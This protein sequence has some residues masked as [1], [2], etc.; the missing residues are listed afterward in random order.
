MRVLRAAGAELEQN[1][2]FGVAGQL[3]RALLSDLPPAGRRAFLAEAP[4]RVRSLAG[5]REALFEPGD[6]GDLTMSHGLFTAMAGAAETRP[7]LLAIDDLHWC[8]VALLEF[9]LYVLHRLDELP[10]ALVMTRGARRARRRRGRARPCGRR[11]PPRPGRRG[12]VGPA[13]ARGAGAPARSRARCAGTARRG[14]RRVRRRAAGASPGARGRRRARASRPARGELHL[15]RVARPRPPAARAR[16]LRSGGGER[17]QGPPH[18]G[19]ATAA[20]PRRPAR[21][22]H[23]RVGAQRDRADRTGV[24]RRANARGSQSAVDRMATRRRVL[25]AERRARERARGRPGRARGVAPA[26]L[27]AG[28]RYRQLRPR[29]AAAVAGTGHRRARRSRASARRPA[30]RMAA[31]RPLGRRALRAVPDRAGR[32]RPGTGRARRGR[33]ARRAAGHRGCAP[34]VLARRASARAEP[35]ARG[36][37]GGTGRRR[38]RRADRRLPRLLPVARD[39]GAGLADARRSRPRTRDRRRGGSPAPSGPTSFTYGSGARRVLGLCEQGT[40]SLRSLRAA[41]RLG[42]NAP[43]RLETMR[44]LVDLGAALRRENRRADAREPLERA[45]DMASRGGAVALS[46]RA[47]I[48]LAAAGARPRRDAL[49]SGPGSLTPRSGGSPSW[50]PPV[51]ATARSRRRC[52]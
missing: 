29:A 43:P 12:F 8:D 39:R 20:G 11:R 28:V 44:A 31:V 25:P 7:T 21:H 42:S 16:A 46:E 4:E 41:V 23:R 37:R 13:P 19:A 26:R 22:H 35:A 17:G 38:D 36:A 27:A 33:P 47:R 6:A 10:V 40:R 51:R 14:R 5:A 3:V 9:V 45:A 34:A 49:F 18:P 15:D 48:E 32:A 50:P 52:S 30:L 24:G 2:A 1:L